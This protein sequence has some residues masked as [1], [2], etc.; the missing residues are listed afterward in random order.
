MVNK[1]IKKT[2]ITISA[3]GVIIISILLAIF[4]ILPV[5]FS[6]KAIEPYKNEELSIN[7]VNGYQINLFYQG[8]DNPRFAEVSEQGDLLV[9]D[10]GSKE[11][12][13]L[14]AD[15]DGDGISD[16]K[17]ILLQGL[18]RAH[19]LA[20]WQGWLYIAETD[21]IFRIRFDAE[22]RRVDGELIPVVTGLPGGGNHW[23][24]TIAFGPDGWLYLSVGSSCNVCLEEDPRRAAITRYR[25][26][27]SGEQ[28]VASGL[29]NSV[30][31]DWSPADGA[32]Y[33][34]ENGRDWLG[35]DFPPEE[36]NR[37]EQGGFYGWPYLN[38]NNVIDPEFGTQLPSGLQGEPP[39]YEF[40]AHNAPLG[41][42]FVRSDAHP[43]AYRQAALVALHGSWNR[44]VKD[45]FKV[46]SLHWHDDGEI[47]ER[48]F[49]TGFLQGDSVS[50]RPVGLAEA[51]DGTLYLTDDLG[52]RVYRISPVTE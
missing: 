9:A 13:L 22:S 2:L 18:D 3:I 39:A 29:R 17:V 5:N 25:P 38:G 46:V 10:T 45:G 24:R 32:L 50:G 33:A 44:S 7:V 14:L 28:I 37:I 43:E 4:Y 21:Q 35:D 16:G 6:I 19:D 48:D 47:E 52:G 34:T 30:G 49:I 31:F 41:M 11:I 15:R 40:A 36:L 20:L 26:D 8:L 51:G 23:T 42:I 12:D 1:V 27:G